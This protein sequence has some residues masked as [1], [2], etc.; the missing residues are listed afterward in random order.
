[1]SEPIDA[2][3]NETQPVKDNKQKNDLIGLSGDLITSLNFK[4]ASFVYLIGVM[5]FSDVFAE[6]ILSNISG[7]YENGEIS[8]KGTMIQLLLLCIVIL[9]MD[10]LIKTNVV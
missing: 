7:I 4:L 9:I 6:N 10:L 8:T 2:E 3:T 5:I 1:M